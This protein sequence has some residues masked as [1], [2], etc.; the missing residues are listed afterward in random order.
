[1][2]EKRLLLALI[3]VE[4]NSVHLRL[5]FSSLFQYAVSL[6]LSESVAF[7]AISV[8]R[9]MREIPEL[10]S[11]VSEIGIS[12]LRKIVSVLT[13]ENQAEWVLKAKTLSSRSLEKEVAKVSPRAATPERSRYVSEKRLD[14]S[15]GVSEEL[16]L[17]LRRVQ[18]QVSQSLGRPASLEEALQ[19]MA[20]FYLR[21]KDPLEK[22][23][24]VIAKK[25]FA[26]QAESCAQ[27][28]GPTQAEP[29]ASGP[30]ESKSLNKLFTGTVRTPIPKAIEHQVRL[31]DQNQC[32]APREKGGVCG[33][34]R[35]IDLH[36][37]KPV[38]QGGKNTAE[39]LTVLCRAHHRLW[40]SSGS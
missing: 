38:S 1:M 25:G 36:H 3:E 16:M 22:A 23:R 13:P 11:E 29:A 14:L 2:A 27:A 31:R 40:H 17:K 35:W 12:K 5:G 18:D 37:I 15:L 30:K 7:S 10:E 28:E 39:N 24:R 21:H 4:K 8:A 9:K 20:T 32:Q 6:G 19:E 34:Q 26:A 33:S